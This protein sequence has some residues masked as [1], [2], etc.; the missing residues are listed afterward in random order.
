MSRFAAKKLRNL[1][2]VKDELMR[3]GRLLS[4]IEKNNRPFPMEKAFTERG[5]EPLIV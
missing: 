4:E 5:D 2:N 3:R 1:S